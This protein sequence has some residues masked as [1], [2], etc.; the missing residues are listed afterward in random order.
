MELRYSHCGLLLGQTNPYPRSICEELIWTKLLPLARLNV[1][2]IQGLLSFAAVKARVQHACETTE[3]LRVYSP[4]MEST[5][6]ASGLAS[7]TP[8]LEGLQT[9]GPQEVGSPE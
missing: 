5:N 2:S 6:T 9:E 4:Y 8:L 3:Q 1:S 7:N